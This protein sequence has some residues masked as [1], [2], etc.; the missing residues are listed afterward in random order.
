MPVGDA[1]FWLVGRDPDFPPGNEPYFGLVDEAS[2]INLNTASS[3]MLEALPG[4]TPDLLEAILLWRRRSTDALGG[5]DMGTYSR[6]DPPRVNK[7]APFE[8]VDELRLVYGATLE[9]LFGED[10]NRNG[11]LDPNEDDGERTAPRDD[12]DGQ[13]LAGISEYVT[14]YS[15]QPD[16]RRDGGRRINISNL[17]T[18]QNLQGL[19]VH[20]SRRLEPGRAMEIIRAI[21]SRNYDSVAEF[22]WDSGMTPEEYALVN[23]DFTARSGTVTG[24]INVN[25]ASEIVLSCIPGIG[26]ENAPMLVAYRLANPDVLTSFAWLRQVLSRSNVAR[27]GRYITDHSYQFSADVVA[28]G[29]FGRGY[30]RAKTVFDMSNGIPRIVYH[31]DLSAYGWALGPTIRQSTRTRET[32]T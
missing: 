15:R 6:L 10:T 16:R 8:S 9:V 32:G 13:L 4:M 26:P 25:T 29:R 27:A 3:A 2:K 20:L 14:V 1:K 23:T 28:V 21:G 19:A 22:M 31:Q 30:A 11:V 5:G 17:S 24:L 18:P 7:S 12:Q